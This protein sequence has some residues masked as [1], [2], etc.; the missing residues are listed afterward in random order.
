VGTGD[1]KNELPRASDG[2]KGHGYGKSHRLRVEVSTTGIDEALQGVSSDPFPTSGYSTSTGLR[3]PPVLAANET[4][5]TQPRY[6]F[7]LASLT[8]QDG[9]RLLGMRQGLTIGVDANEGDAPERPIECRVTTPNFRFPDG[10]VSWHLVIENQPQRSQAQVLTNAQN[11]VKLQSDNPAMLYQTFFNT[12]ET[13]TGAPVLYIDGLT[14]YTPPDLTT[15][16]QPVAGCGNL[17]DIRFPW[18]SGHAWSS[19]GPGG[20]EIEGGGRLS[21]YASVLQSNP[22][23]RGTPTLTASSLSSSACPEECFIQNFTSTV[24]EVTLGPVF[25][26]I[27]GA[28]LVEK[29]VGA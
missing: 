28:L 7:T 25:W 23:T 8:F 9:I 19:F 3:I 24:D 2:P 29:L 1:K 26:R 20:I 6:L 10:N 5:A 14:A 22:A 15:G 4:P 17:H 12:N 11:W 21:L 18:D 16:W 13:P 27:M